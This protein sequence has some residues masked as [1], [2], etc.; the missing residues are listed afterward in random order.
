MFIVGIDVAKRKHD[1]TVI[2]ADGDIVCKSFSI[3]NNCS[4]YNRLMEKLRKLTN[5]RSE[6]IFALE[7]TAH[8]WLAL[9]TRLL[10]EGFTVVVPNPIQTASMREMCLHHN[11]TDAID[12]YAIAEVIRFGRY[13]ASNV[14]QE[15]L[16]A[17]KELCRNR[18]YLIDTAS[19]FKRKIIT[20][21]DRIFP[22]YETFFESMFCKTSIA[23]LKRYPTPQKLAN[24]QLSKLTELL[25]KNSGGHFGE[26]KAKEMKAAAKTSFGIEDYAG[27]Y[28]KLMAAFIDQQQA[29]QAKAD[30]LEKDIAVLLKEFDTPLTSIPGIGTL[31]AASILSEIGDV[32]RFPFADKL[33]SYIGLNPTIRQSGNFTAPNSHMSKHGSP[34]LRR[35]IWM[36]SQVAVLHDPMF[37]AFYERKRSQGKNYMTA[38]GHVA[39]KMVSVIYA[40]MRDRIDYVP[41]IQAA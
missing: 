8:Y 31:L 27:T 3:T 34:Y 23:V 29:L 35:A 14:S 17:L 32:T 12:S 11:K 37:Q 24:A 9:Y 6:F 1:V 5:I 39:K 38:M 18:F 30:E 40:V 15:K 41:V 4:G 20:L 33:A 28:S 36:A 25:R 22:E 13:S 7:S 26:W 16:F 21:L 10:K 2:T 19:D